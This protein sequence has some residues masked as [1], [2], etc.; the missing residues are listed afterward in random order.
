MLAY[1]Y[2]WNEN[3]HTFSDKQVLLLLPCSTVPLN[4]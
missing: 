1:L 3:L 2:Q 4:W